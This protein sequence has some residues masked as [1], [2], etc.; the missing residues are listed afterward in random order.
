MPTISVII[1]AYNAESTILDTIASVQK[2]TFSDFELIVINDGSRDRTLKLLNEIKDSRLKVFSYKNGGLSVARNRGIYHAKGDFITFL[3]ADDLWTTDKLELQLEALQKHPEAG[4]AYSWSYFMDDKNEYCNTG[5][6]ILFQGN[7]FANLLT[8]NFIASGSNPLIRRQAIESVG[9]FEPSVSG[10]ADW[11]YWLRL[12]AQWSF[13]VVPK[14]QVFY[15]QSSS[16]M[17]SQIEFMEDCQFK[18]LERAFQI[19]P[20]ELQVLKQASFAYV[21]RYSSKLCLTRIPGKEGVQKA[22]QKLCQAIQLDPKILLQ[23][24]T[25]KLIIKLLFKTILAPNISEHLLQSITK[26]RAT[27]VQKLNI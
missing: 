8:W 20:K 22:R 14:P 7:V 16:S 1:P 9:D 11:D 27:D 10:A 2:Q 13:V 24:E 25:L 19:A 18:V 12:A 3:D 6:P 5:Q 23:I 17:S 26:I 21:Y 15:R 4:V